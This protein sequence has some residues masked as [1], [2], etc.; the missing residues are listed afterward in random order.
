VNPDGTG[1][2]Q[3]NIA[4]NFQPTANFTIVEHGEAVELIFAVPGNMNAFT[5]LKQN[6]D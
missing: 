6:A 3:L 4:P 5:L 1:T 2:L